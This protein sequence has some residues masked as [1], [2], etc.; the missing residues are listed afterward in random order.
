MLSLCFAPLNEGIQKC[1]T[2]KAWMATSKSEIEWIHYFYSTNTSTM[3][4]I[5]SHIFEW[6]ENDEHFEEER[7]TYNVQQASI[8]PQLHYQVWMHSRRDTW[9]IFHHRPLPEWM[10]ERWEFDYR[11]L[12]TVD[13]FEINFFFWV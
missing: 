1:F 10:W 12:K 9:D 3:M 4:M 5:K 7:V 6:N 11:F 8:C 2:K 13:E